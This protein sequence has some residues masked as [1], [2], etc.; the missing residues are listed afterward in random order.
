MTQKGIHMPSEQRR[1]TVAKSNANVRVECRGP[2]MIV[3]LDRPEARNA[4]D[5]PTAGALASAIRRFEADESASIGV[6]Y[7]SGGNF[8]AGLDL[9]ALAIDT[10]RSVRYQAEGDAP[11]GVARM[12]DLSKPLIAAVEGY[13]VAAGLELA[14]MCDLRVASRESTFGMFNRRWGVALT[15]GGTFRLPRLVG[16]SRALDMI[17]TGR[18]VRGPEALEIGLVNRLVGPGETLEAA[19]RLAREIARF[20]QAALRADRRSVLEQWSLDAEEALKNEWRHGVVTWESGEI[21][22]GAARFASGKGRHG[23]FEEI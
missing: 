4:L 21:R 3:V 17:L 5:G 6:L 10:K 22:S 23:S 1:D 2:V 16:Q 7:G 20:P 12:T 15:D 19:V 11:T 8:C 9:K 13:A 14:A 18:P